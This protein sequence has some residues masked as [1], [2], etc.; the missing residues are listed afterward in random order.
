MA[1]PLPWVKYEELENNGG[2]FIVSPLNRGMGTTL[3][4]SLRRVL[5]ASME[6]HAITNVNIEGVQHEFSTIPNVVEDVI[7]IIANLKQVVFRSNAEEPAT[8]TIEYKGKGIVSAKDIKSDGTIEVVNPDSHIA[9]V[10]EDG[11]L[12][13]ELTVERGAGY[14]ASEIGSKDNT[15]R[16][17]YLDASF[18][19]IVRV[20]HNV[21]NIRVGKE[22]DY[23]RLTLDVWTNGS[24]DAEK[25][26]TDASSIL[27]DKFELF[28]TL[29]QPPEVEDA[30]SE[31]E[32]GDASKESAL[33]LSIDD[34]ELSA[35]SSN[36]LKRAG[37]ETVAELIEKDLSELIQ[38]KNFGKK[39]ADEINEKLSQFGLSL[40]GAEL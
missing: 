10:S 32:E 25:A 39:S 31:E 7:D 13:I 12:N 28:K 9:E 19:P 21:E 24:V 37:V 6:G 17:I 36:C 38:I 30:D 15:A 34:L 4:N 16:S 35:R 18:S 40:K 26:V 27:A 29:N 1:K 3:G 14:Q 22:L 5:L 8:L 33:G 23:D 20:N 2:R 11:K